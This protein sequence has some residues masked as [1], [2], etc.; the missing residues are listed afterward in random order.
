M[1][2]L[3]FMLTNQK[4]ILTSFMRTKILANTRGKP[5]EMIV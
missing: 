5:L 3:I 2:E 1:F 4:G